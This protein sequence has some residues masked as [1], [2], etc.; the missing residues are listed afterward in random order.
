MSSFF[1][2]RDGGPVSK[3]PGIPDP[4]P[5]K[6]LS[7]DIV[8]GTQ[9]KLI[10]L[11][12]AADK[13]RILTSIQLSCRQPGIIEIVSTLTGP[14]VKEIG[15]GRTGAGKYNFDLKW[16]PFL[17]LKENEKVEV[18]FTISSWGAASDVEMLLQSSLDDA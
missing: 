9:K 2:T 10:S 17:E 16:F 4:Q 5:V 6:V 8:P 12:T 11:V 1:Y 7:G 14:I 3:L 15:F 13:V 18:F